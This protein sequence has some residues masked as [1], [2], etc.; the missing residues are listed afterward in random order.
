MWKDSIR[1]IVVIFQTTILRFVGFYV[2]RLANDHGYNFITK[3]KKCFPYYV[4]IIHKKILSNCSSQ[5][6]NIE[7]KN[8][9][10]GGLEDYNNISDGIFP[11]F[12]DE[13]F[14]AIFLTHF[15][16]GF[17]LLKLSP[18]HF[19]FVQCVHRCKKECY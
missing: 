8:S 4:F 12:S 1:N 3:K 15:S 14:R 6:S 9:Q 19:A 7:S 18:F 10:N 13:F 2:R 11:H 17:F 16:D 5:T